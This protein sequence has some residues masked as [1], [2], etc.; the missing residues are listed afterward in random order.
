MILIKKVLLI[1]SIIG[2]M[3]ATTL[4]EAITS[5][6]QNNQTL[7][8]LHIEDNA[9][10][11][12]YQ[13]VS[14]TFNPTLNIGANLLRLDGDTRAVQVGTT[15]TGF[16]KFGLDLYDGGKNSATKRAK[17]YE[18]N[19]SKL[20]TTT[21]TKEILLQVVT[22]F[23]N[24][25]TVI[26]NIKVFKEKSS[27]LKAQ[28]ERIKE[29]YE[30]KMATI[31]EV[32]KLQSEY[33]TNQYDIQNLQYQKAQLLQNLSLLTG[34]IITNLDNSNLPDILNL[35]YQ[36]SEAIKAL[37]LAVKAQKENTNAIDS[38]N[39]PHIKV[40]DS[41]NIYNYDDYN[42]KILN[43]LPDQ[44]N[45]LSLT[46]TYNLFDTTSKHK[47]ESAKLQELALKQKLSY[48]ISKEKMKFNLAKQ[49]LKIQKLKII[50]LKSA[51]EMGNSVYNMVKIKYQ[52][53][54]VD[55]ITYLDALSKKVYNKA[56]YIQALN[57]YEIAKAT[58]YFSSG[59][60]FK[61]IPNFLIWK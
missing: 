51:V 45:Q 2:V 35:Q 24:T 23:F 36:D 39:K 19:I 47:T 50:S 55:N 27:T 26:E 41:Y 6:M 44:Q 38:V 17:K 32:L 12:E 16:V 56:L 49:K 57:D 30:L 15:T 53:G 13:S 5:T 60:D 43:D 52:N 9:K 33:E 61:T 54:I 42:S 37:K 31:D 40:E 10:F 11:K 18:S 48:A 29:K 3:N 8:S 14:N 1:S 20:D 34:T 7:K 25:K 4:K 59:I 22:T 46:L 28:Y 58:Y 21:N